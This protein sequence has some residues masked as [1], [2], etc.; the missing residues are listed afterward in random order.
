MQAGRNA[1]EADWEAW[2]QFAPVEGMPDVADEALPDLLPASYFHDKPAQSDRAALK[3]ALDNAVIADVDPK[4][5]PSP[6]AWLFFLQARNNKAFLQKLALAFAPTKAEQGKA[7]AFFD[8]G[9]NLNDRLAKIRNRASGTD[10][11]MPVLLG[12]S[13]GIA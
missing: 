5:C 2:G 4:S 12:G 11:T 3:W 13:E 7:Q 10:S 1:R 8:D 9:R 6:K